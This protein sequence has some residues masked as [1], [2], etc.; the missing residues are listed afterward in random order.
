MSVKKI[1]VYVAAYEVAAWVW[2]KHLGASSSF[3]LP[4]DILSNFLP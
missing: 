1:I 2:N 3:K 4:G